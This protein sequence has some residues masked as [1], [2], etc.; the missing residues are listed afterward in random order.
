MDIP[1]AIKIQEECEDGTVDECVK[2]P[3]GKK[4]CV[5]GQGAG[6][7]NVFSICAL[8][9]LLRDVIDREGEYIFKPEY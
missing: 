5:S 6:F 8:L 2:C 9:N 3:I 1:E 7:D 4:L